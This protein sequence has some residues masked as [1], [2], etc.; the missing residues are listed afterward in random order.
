[1]DKKEFAKRLPK[2]DLHVHLDGSLREETLREMAQEKG[3]TIPENTF[4]ET[5]NDLG[6]YLQGFGYTTA[7]LRDKENLERAA[8]E[9][10]IDSQKENILYIEPRFAPQLLMD[11]NLSME[12][13]IEAV[14]KGLYRAKKEFNET[15]SED[16]PTFE[17]GMIIC[18]MR[19]F[20]KNFSPYYETLFEENSDKSKTEILQKGALEAAKGAVELKESGYPIVALDLAGQESGYSAKLFE[21][22]FTYA[23]DNLMHTTVHAGEA[24]NATSIYNAVTKLQADRIGHG[25]ALFDESTLTDM[26]ETKRHTYLTE[27]ADYMANQ[28][29]AIEVCLTSNQQTMPHIKEDLEAHTV[30]EMVEYGL[31]VVLCSDNTLVSKT[32]VQKE[33]EHYID[34]FDPS[35]EELAQLALNGLEKSF[36]ARTYPEKQKYI[37]NVKKAVETLIETLKNE[38]RESVKKEEKK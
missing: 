13:V 38:P 11:E 5:Y 3:I 7:V 19:N 31:P 8:Y 22:A 10:A 27:L 30:K 6:E 1:M 32:D 2:A 24:D 14:D 36:F 23:K 16:E 15:R 35:Q 25:F 37:E 17:Y 4:K 9:L 26:D 28:K 33:F 21:E 29:T 34:T 18:A 20:E 12:G